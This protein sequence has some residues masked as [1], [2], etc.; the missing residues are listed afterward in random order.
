MRPDLDL[1][2]NL[3]DTTP[4]IVPRPGSGKSPSA[5]RAAES[6]VGPLSPSYRWWLT[7]YG[8]GS[9]ARQEIATVGPLHHIAAED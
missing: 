5:V 8:E 1:L 7:V 9:V 2:R 3:I 6:V 4:D